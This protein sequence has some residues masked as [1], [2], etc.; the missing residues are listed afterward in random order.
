LT[1]TPCLDIIKMWTGEREEKTMDDY[2]DTND[3]FLD[4]SG[5]PC[6]DVN[7]FDGECDDLEEL[8]EYVEENGGCV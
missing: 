7:N 4:S 8:R 3:K 5:S 6:D 1:Q 2:E